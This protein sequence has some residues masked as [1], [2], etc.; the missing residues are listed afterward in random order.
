MA[1][2][3][4]RAFEHA[5]LDV[6]G[7]EEAVAARIRDSDLRPQ[8]VMALDHWAY[9]ADALERP[10]IDGTA[11]GPGS[12]RRSG[13][14]VGRPLPRAGAVGRPRPPAAPGGGGAAAAGRSR[15][16]RADRRPRW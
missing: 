5:G 12:A 14:A 1:E 3:Y 4:A 16:P 11:A 6:R 10:A 2:A 8:L 9:V 15:R 7:D 13:P